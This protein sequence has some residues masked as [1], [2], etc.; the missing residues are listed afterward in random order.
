MAPPTAPPMTAPWFDF[1]ADE[2]SVAE[3]V[4][5]L[6]GVLVAAGADVGGWLV[7]AGEIIVGVAAT[8]PTPV[9]TREG[10]N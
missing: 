1:E 6:V 9:R 8:A 5:V 2:L 10:V 7:I 4:A 3:L